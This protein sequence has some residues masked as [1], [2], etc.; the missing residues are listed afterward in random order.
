MCTAWYH[1]FLPG[2]WQQIGKPE[3]WLTSFSTWLG[4][5]VTLF[6]VAIAAWLTYR[7]TRR[8]AILS[9]NTQVRVERLRHR[10]AALEAVWSL[11]AY[12]SQ[13]R[14][15]KAIIRWQQNKKEAEGK[16]YYYYFP[17]LE[18]FYLHAVSE[19]FYD[20]HAGLHLPA[21][22]RDLVFRY[23]HAVAP[24]Y[25]AHLR[26]GGQDDVG[27]VKNPVIAEKLHELYRQLNERLK[28]ELDA[29]YQALEVD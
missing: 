14:S 25:Y 10:I 23:V 4:M 13:R 7:Y 5:F 8:N 9:H 1:W 3:V 15:D 2:Y 18:T 29:T 24:L 22:I 16:R 21:D 26:Q 11:L 19:V 27:I 17:S 28:R 6:S 12:M 20:Q